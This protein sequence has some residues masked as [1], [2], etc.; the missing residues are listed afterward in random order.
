MQS[1]A[2]L[3]MLVVAIALFARGRPSMDAVALMVIALLPFTG[4]VSAGEAISG[5]ADQSVVLIAALFVIGEGLVRTGVARRIGEHIARLSGGRETRL[6]ALLMLAVAGLG[7]FMSST[8]VVAIFL[9]IV[10]RVARA[11]GISTGRLMMPLSMAALISGMMTLVATAPNLVVNAELERRGHAGF[12]FFAFTPFGIPVLLLAIAYMLFVRRRLAAE[13]ADAA[14]ARASMAEWVE[15]YGLAA[16]E[17]RYRVSARS[18]L[19]DRRL[20]ELDLR[21][22]DGINILAIERQTPRGRTILSPGAGSVLRAGDILLIDADST[23]F[24]PEAFSSTHGLVRVPLSGGY[25]L[26]RQQEIGMVEAIVPPG[27]RL[28]GRTPVDARYRS[29]TGLHILAVRRRGEQLETPAART[30]LEAGDVLLLIGR[31]KV[32]A[33]ARPDRH[34]LVMLDP[35]EE[36]EDYAP[37][38]RRAP[39]AVAILFAVV[40][41]MATGIIPNVQAALLGCLAMGLFGCV[42]ARSAYRS[43]SWPTLILIAGMLPFALALERTGAVDAAAASISGALGE[44]SPRL[45]LAALFLVTAMLGMFISNTATAVLMAPVALGVASDIGASPYPFAMIVAL[46]AS[47]A[48]MTPVSSPVNMLAA[49]P[50][51]YGFRDFLRIG[52]PFAVLTML[53]SVALV[54]ILLPF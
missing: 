10:L 34:D 31:W 15:S 41:A 40:A 6:V 46:A 39:Y 22:R 30:R 28:A 29:A 14:P 36:A 54:P 42:D 13:K 38:A 45:L 35:P 8:G 32:I 23:D 24:D 16:R 20:D 19:A 2:V 11:T 48:F 1:I 26:D 44:G 3:A 33:R 12:G 4:T 43:V 50:G 37:A 9:P 25:F 52:A 47:T 27:S 7:A 51:G 21:G 17:A 18:D 49:G 5:F 53:V